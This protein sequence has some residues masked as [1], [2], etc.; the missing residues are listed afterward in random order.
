MAK[1]KT[2]VSI[3]S[4]TYTELCEEIP[5]IKGFNL[6]ERTNENN[7]EFFTHIFTWAI[8]NDLMFV[9]CSDK[10]YIFAEI[11]PEEEK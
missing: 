10:F 7:E 4:K 5:Q 1:N 11:A 8:E 6:R 9:T 2:K 3:I